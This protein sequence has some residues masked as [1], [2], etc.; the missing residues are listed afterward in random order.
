VP[1]YASLLAIGVMLAQNPTSKYDQFII[2]ASRL[3]NKTKHNCITI[4]RE[5]LTM[6]NALHKLK[7][8]LLGNKFVFYVNH[9]TLVYLVNKPHVSKRIPIWLLLFLEYKFIVVYKLGRIH[10]VADVLSRLLDNSKPLGIPYQIID[11]SLLFVE[12][13]WMQKMKSYLEIS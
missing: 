9:M 2:Y 11:A 8:F 13:I 6:V 12:P 10:V 5:A 7:H 4:D 1:T 3:L